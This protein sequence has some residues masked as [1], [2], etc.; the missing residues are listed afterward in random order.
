MSHT[1]ESYTTN[2]RPVGIANGYQ[3]LWLRARARVAAGDPFSLTW[4]TG[5]RFYT[6]TTVA[7]ADMDVLFTE[8]GANDPNFNLRR[9]QALLLRVRGAEDHSFISVL[10]PHGEYNGAEEFTVGSRGTITEIRHHRAGQTDALS[11]RTASGASRTLLL[12]YDPDD[13]AAHSMVVDDNTYSWNG[14]YALFAEE[15]RREARE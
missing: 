11:F 8:L 4:L 12:S 3:H 5:N 2:L 13:I 1:P 10:E 6:Y 7:L 15:R 9:Q 14:Y